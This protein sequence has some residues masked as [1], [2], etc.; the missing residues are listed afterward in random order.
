VTLYLTARGLTTGPMPDG[1]R[2]V[3]MDFDFLSHELVVATSDGPRGRMPLRPMSVADFW[4]EFHERTEALGVAT[5]IHPLPSEIPDPVPFDEDTAHAAYDAE[6]VERFFRALSSI[7]RVFRE[8]RAR[9]L[10]KSSPSHF[11]WGSFDLA[12]TRF[13]GRTAPPHPAGIPGLPDWVARE[14]Y[15]HEVSSAGFWPGGEVHPH[16][17]VYSYAYPTPDGF[18]AAEVGPEGAVWVEDLGEWVLPYAVVRASSDPAVALMTFLES[19]YAAAA[20]LADWDRDRLEWGERWPGR[21]P[22]T[23]T[24]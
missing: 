2:T 17:I 19:T 23:P 12:V 11:F 1:H 6:A 14:A 15:S 3:Q 8:F 20:D 13:S 16:P 22:F 7:D 5:R 21:P 18:A 9:F 10:G 4:H 24:E